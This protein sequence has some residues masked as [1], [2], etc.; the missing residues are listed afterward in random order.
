MRA[1]RCIPVDWRPI[2]T[3]PQ[4]LHFVYLFVERGESSFKHSSMSWSVCAVQVVV[5]AGSRKFQAHACAVPLNR[6]SGVIS[7]LRGCRA[8]A[9]SFLL[10]GFDRFRV[11]SSRHHVIVSEAAP[12]EC[13]GSEPIMDPH[14]FS[15][16]EIPAPSGSI[17]VCLIAGACGRVQLA[18]C[19]RLRRGEEPIGRRLTPKLAATGVENR[20]RASEDRGAGR[21]PDRGARSSGNAVVSR[22]FSRKRSTVTGMTTKSSTP[23]C[24]ATRRPAASGGSIG[25][26]RKTCEC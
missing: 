10:L 22:I 24:P 17:V 12:N 2:S 8:S 19:D 25:R 3:A 20:R 23:A 6:A 14:V 15:T 21:Q 1:A 5:H 26:S 9:G 16:L 4:A 13:A 7:R 18:R 11:E